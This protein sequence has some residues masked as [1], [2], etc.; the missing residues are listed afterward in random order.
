MRRLLIAFLCLAMLAV[1]SLAWAQNANIEITSPQ[2]LS[3]VHLLT[4]D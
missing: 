3:D 1:F 2:A 4:R